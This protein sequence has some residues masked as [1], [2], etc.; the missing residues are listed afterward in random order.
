MK[1]L[2]L[3]GGF[4]TRLRPL[5]L[6]VPKPIVEMANRSM[7]LHQIAALARVGVDEVVLAVNYR[8]AMM[9]KFLEHAEEELGVKITYSQEEEPLGT[10]GPLALA[11]EH[12]SDGDCFFVLNSD[13]TCEYP[14]EDLLAF[15]RSHG[16]EGTIMVTQVDE[17]SKYGVVVSDSDGKIERFVEKPQVFV[18]N[19]INAGI[20]IFD[21][22]VLKRIPLRP[23]SIER[24]VFPVMAAE[25]QIY[26]MP[27]EGF[28]MDVG[29]PKD[30]LTG[31]GLYLRSLLKREPERLAS[32]PH[33]AGAVLVD[34]S[35]SIGDNCLIGPNVVIG[36]DCR[37]GDGVRLSNCTLLAGSEIRSHSWINQSIIGWRSIVGR[38]VRIEG[39]S[40]LGE[41][42]QIADE[43]YL[44]GAKILPHK[45]I[46][47]SVSE[48]AVIM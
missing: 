36:P 8:P 48:P 29:Q 12:L 14:F 2:I 20:Y 10:A 28:W 9:A 24:E 32:G 40:V 33:I 44:N 23:T 46:S 16:G 26:S 30:F 25:G 18:S 21:P 1:A 34:E 6:T 7:V 4:G 42:V 47:T 35:A 15:H 13:V 19:K 5:T 27:L 11:A 39:V 43:L 17:P 31:T 38:W 37:V 45:S 41:D 3:V 22:T